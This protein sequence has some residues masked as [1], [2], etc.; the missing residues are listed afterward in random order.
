MK[1]VHKLGPPPPILKMFHLLSDF[2]ENEDKLKK[3]C[4][5]DCAPPLKFQKS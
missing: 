4:K 5:C 2:G 1:I 3:N